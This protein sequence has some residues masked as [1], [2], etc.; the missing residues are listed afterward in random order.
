M[1]WNVASLDCVATRRSPLSC[2]L[3]AQP[4]AGSSARAA[5]F[6]RGQ[7]LGRSERGALR[8]EAWVNRILALDYRIRSLLGIRLN[9]A[10]IA[11]LLVGNTS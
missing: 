5:S 8:S 3:G 10:E 1:Q 7:H 6:E 11:E 2:R 9:Q 4:G